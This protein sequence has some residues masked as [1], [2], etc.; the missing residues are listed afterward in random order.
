MRHPLLA[1]AALHA[2]SGAGV[3]P[4]LAQ[5]TPA[6][7]A[8]AREGPCEG[9]RFHEF[10]FW[11]GEW[12]VRRP[13]G[14]VAGT[15]AITSEEAGCAIVEHWT[16][17]AGGTGQS[18]N[19]YDPAADRWRQIWIGLGLVLAMEGG[20]VNGAMI[21]EGPLQYV[22]TGRVTRLR[23]VWTPLPDGRV[24]QEFQESE[25]GGQ[26]WTLWFDGYYSRTEAAR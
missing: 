26:T 6:P 22:A 16:S 11:V 15:N 21:L 8:T 20:L 25:N 2:L 3:P 14:Q 5:S 12:T 7:P 10:D 4:S 18:L 9:P 13:D 17:A 24:R 1:F 23:G 19:F